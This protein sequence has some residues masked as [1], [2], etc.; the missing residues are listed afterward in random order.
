VAAVFAPVYFV[1]G[2]GIAWVAEK[3][4]LLAIAVMSGLL[5]W[6]HAENINRLFKGTE[7]RLGKKKTV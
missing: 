5:V 3:H 4:V 6:R 7:S 2:D 1:F